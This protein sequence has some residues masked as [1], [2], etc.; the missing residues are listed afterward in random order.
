LDLLLDDNAA[1]SLPSEHEALIGTLA[2]QFKGRLGD[3]KETD[4]QQDITYLVNKTG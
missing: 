4:Q 2:G 1:L 3:L